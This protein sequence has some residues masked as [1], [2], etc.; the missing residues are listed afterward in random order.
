MIKSKSQVVSYI[1]CIL[2]TLAIHV[3][4]CNKKLLISLFLFGFVFVCVCMFVFFYV[5]LYVEM[6]SRDDL[7]TSV[8][9][10]GCHHLKYFHRLLCLTYLETFRLTNQRTFMM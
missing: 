5:F 4:G 10:N 2:S 9:C 3:I 8:F 6:P 1:L 7:D